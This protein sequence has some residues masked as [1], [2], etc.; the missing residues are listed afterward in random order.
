VE[1]EMIVIF[2]P[3]GPKTIIDTTPGT[4]YHHGWLQMQCDR[5]NKS[6][7]RVAEI[8]KEGSQWSL[9]VN[10]IGLKDDNA[11]KAWVEKFNKRIEGRK[12]ACFI[13]EE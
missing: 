1:Y 6:P 13:T 9:W 3:G 4:M 12:L 10:N 2:R 8:H 11:R 5:I 7:G